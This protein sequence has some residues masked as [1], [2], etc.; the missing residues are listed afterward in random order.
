[1][2][3]LQGKKVL[4]VDDEEMLR[5]VLI[6]ALEMMG[7]QVLDAANGTAALALVREHAPQLVIT[8]LRMP[9]GDGLSLLSAIRSEPEPHPRV[10]LCSAF[11]DI[12]NENARAL[13]AFA[14]F[15]K[16]FE[17]KSFRQAILDA[18]R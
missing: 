1:M 13:G 11:S 10:I 18:L 6:D 7:A 8:D 5:E 14:L 16:P 17:W 4:V 15:T 9:N 3:E 2:N 12:T